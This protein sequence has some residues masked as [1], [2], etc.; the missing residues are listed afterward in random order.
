MND[1][2]DPELDPVQHGQAAASSAAQN[3]FSPT[4]PAS[5]TGVYLTVSDVNV[6]MAQLAQATQAATEAA[7]V[8]A[9]VVQARGSSES[10]GLEARDLL[11]ILPKPE[12]F[13]VDKLEDEH[14]RWVSWYWQFRQY[15][16]AVDSQ[17]DREITLLERDLHTEVV[18]T[19]PE[20]QARSFQLYALLSAL[21][22]GRA[23]QI[24]KQV[25]QQRGY[26]A[27][28]MLLLQ[29]QPPSK[30][31]SLGILSALTQLKGFNTKE[32]YLP[33][34][35]ELERGFE[36]YEIASG[37]A[38]QASLKSALLLRS[39]SGVMRQHISA[40]LPEDASYTTLREAILRYERTQFKWGTHNLFGTDPVLLGPSVKSHHEE[41][42][43]M[44]VDA[45]TW[46]GKGKDGKG[47]GKQ[48]KGKGKGKQ[49][50]QQP[51]NGKGKDGK[52]NHKG[53]DKGKGKQGKG[54][55]KST[56]ECYTCGKTGH[57]QRDCWQN[58]NR[59]QQVGEGGSAV[60]TV[61]PSASASNSGATA[62]AAGTV[63]RVEGGL[64]CFDMSELEQCAQD[65]DYSF[66][67][68][69]IS[70]CGATLP[71]NP[72][73]EYRLDASDD[74]ETIPWNLEPGL[75]SA[76]TVFKSQHVRAVKHG[77]AS[78]VVIDS[79]ADLSC[80]PLSFAASGRKV[81]GNS[82]MRVQ[83]AQGGAMHVTEERVVEFILTDRDSVPVIIKERCIVCDVTQPILSF[84]RLVKLGWFP[85]R[86][87][88]GDMWLSHASSGVEIPMWFKG[89][90]LAVDATIRRV[91]QSSPLVTNAVQSSPL[92]TD[93]VQSSPLV[94]DAVQSSPLVT[95]A[96]QS[97][98]SVTDAVQSSS[99]VITE[100][101]DSTVRAVTSVQVTVEDALLTSLSYGWQIGASGHFVWR[102]Q[103]TR[104]VDPSMIAP[105]S[106]PYRT[107]ML[108]R[109]DTAAWFV[110]EH[111]SQW[112]ELPDVEAT[113]PGGAQCEVITFLHV[114]PEPLRDLGITVPAG[115]VEPIEFSAPDNA[116]SRDDVAF[117][118]FGPDEEVPE[119][120]VMDGQGEPMEVVPDAPL[121]EQLEVT[122]EERSAAAP[123]PLILDGIE[124]SAS[125]G[126]AVLKAA[127]SKL[128]LSTSG[129]KTRLFN[130][131][132]SYVEKQKL[133]LEVEIA[134]DAVAQGSREPKIQ[135]V[136][137]EPSAQEKL[138]HE[139]THLPFASWCP[140]CVTM[141]AMPDR[142]ENLKDAARDVPSIAFDFCFTGYDAN[143][144]SFVCY[145][146]EPESGAALK[147]MVAHDSHTGSV[148]AVP[149]TSK[150]DVRH[151][152]IEL[153]RFAQ[154]LGHVTIELRCD[155]EPSTL[156]LQ[157]AVINARQRL[158]LQTLER[159]PSV[160]AHASQGYVE[161]A[162]DSI[163]KLANTLLDMVRHRT[164]LSL[165]SDHPVFSWAFVHS[166]W[167]LNRYRVTGNLTAYERAAGARYSG[168]IVPYGEPVFCQ[169]TPR[170]KG[171]PR[172]LLGIFLGKS[173][174]DMFIVGGKGGVR[175][176]RSVRRTG[177]PWSD[178]VKLYESL[179]G[180]PWDY[181]SGVLGTKFVPMPKLRKPDVQRLP[182]GPA[183]SG[184][185]LM[186]EAASLPPTT[187]G[188]AITPASMAAGTPLPL[189]M[190]PPSV[191]PER[192]PPPDGARAM[193]TAAEGASDPNAPD[194]VNPSLRGEMPSTPEH[195]LPVMG[196]P[197]VVQ[198]ETAQAS[199]EVEPNVAPT[200]ADTGEPAA[201]VP[202]IRTVT[203]GGNSYALNDEGYDADFEE[204]VDA[205]TYY[206]MQDAAG[207]P[208]SDE[209]YEAGDAAS[210]LW[211]V[212][213]G[214]G[215]PVLTDSEL[216]N[217]DR[218][219]DDVEVS[220]LVAKA[221]MRQVAGNESTEGMKSLS[222]K[223]VRSWR[224]KEKD[225]RPHYLRRS[226]LVAREFKWLEERQGL[227]SPATSTSV[228]KL[229]P[230][231]FLIWR[232]VRPEIQYG[233]ASIDVKDA[234]LEVPQET[235]LVADMPKDFA[236]SGKYVFLRC[237]PG[238]RDGSQRWFQFYVNYLR[239]NIQV[240]SCLENPAI[241]RTEYGPM[242]LHI[243]DDLVLAPV[244]W[245]KGKLIPLLEQRFEISVTVASVPGDVFTFLKRKHTILEHGI[246]VETPG[247]YIKHMA[248]ILGIK[249]GSS[250]NTPYLPE[251]IRPDSS[252]PLDSAQTTRFRSAL[253]VALYVSS[254]RYDISY[255]VRVLAGF[256]ATPTIL[257]MKGLHRLVKY[258]MNTAEYGVLLQP[259]LPGSSLF[260]ENVHEDGD[261]CMEVYTDADWSGNKVTRKS[262]GAATFALNGAVFHHMCRSHR[263][264]SLSSCESEW[265]AAVS[266]SCEGIYLRSIFRFMAN[267]PCSLHLKVDNSACRQLALRQGV[268]KTRHIEGR[269]LWL[270]QA[271]KD[272]ILDIGAVASAFNLG[273]LSTK[274]HSCHRLRCLL[275]LH[276]FVDSFTCAPVGA[277]S[278]EDLMMKQNFKAALKQVKL[279]LC[280][281]H[282]W[283][284][285]PGG[286]VS[287]MAKQIAM[288]TLLMMPSG[289]EAAV[290]IPAK[291]EA[292]SYLFWVAMTLM[293]LTGFVRA[294]SCIR[295]YGVDF[296]IVADANFEQVLGFLITGAIMLA[297]SFNLES[298]VIAFAILA[299]IMQQRELNVARAVISKL[300]RE[301]SE[302]E[303][304]RD[305][306][307][308][309][310]YVRV[311]NTG[312]CFHTSDCGHIR[313]KNN[314]RTLR[315]CTDCFH[316]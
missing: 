297:E 308:M 68:N 269:M 218:L 17:F 136:P 21:I 79:G 57:L 62:A 159:N 27:L 22:K 9:S 41:P 252:P 37:E 77:T 230:L 165:C 153:M 55:G 150:G 267:S 306:Q 180:Q 220:R 254:D 231:L 268:G 236:G 26:E 169:V 294:L 282:N 2:D 123:E 12:P 140:H 78:M 288:L 73:A 240:E 14:A 219:A 316:G 61:A 139:A 184:V 11:K 291:S 117:D 217:L 53:K 253:G 310:R 210:A 33:Q 187:P 246:L 276:G 60:S 251:L 225:K 107:T 260:H 141:R 188:G 287:K 255:A 129:S 201:K 296:N 70:S 190:A 29:F 277:D 113:L 270:Q 47:K 130:R 142:M 189:P 266:G 237:V 86:S 72:V 244:D 18:I 250:Y 99:L 112:G 295:G 145:D 249:H 92:V 88:N 196:S 274:M 304:D 132:K 49:Q 137:K 151:L 207:D 193:P 214:K 152:G 259:K 125:S 283:N 50:Q 313:G 20:T 170:Q 232:M 106:W 6:L 314:V 271:V 154:S 8:A 30:V 194:V 167:L 90:S 54:R 302:L 104:F 182:D 181:G 120:V 100:I 205:E 31:R 119:A 102:G 198:T 127:A 115:M 42:V 39:L 299:L 109:S 279:D 13:K 309:Y 5:A 242:L 300:V 1:D 48:Q 174:N 7:R 179:C 131:I 65:A 273:D 94:T 28:R 213:Q 89:F 66:H 4:S 301:R 178:E 226:R 202:R 101:P 3:P 183:G 185:G 87:S 32:P 108:R 285:M 234:F 209:W 315:R 168:R 263:T 256:M 81:M 221:V 171:N 74:D 275:F 195:L 203:F 67:V 162:V 126:L 38:V 199:M 235:P 265:Y 105:T 138:L 122:G 175:L 59:V 163:R 135:P 186:D 64:M 272:K 238:Q 128:N 110:V 262:Y 156:S 264:V 146:K 239:S 241:M 15:L 258:L 103:S 114:A 222:S 36:Q 24:V 144:N 192:V 212:D 206:A 23:F 85:C 176:S 52:Q 35:L 82:N 116:G 292:S 224:H 118:F 298:C 303:R 75:A 71:E 191:I 134:A 111:C 204:W 211:F 63:R 148:L 248:E 215:E 166:A 40:S 245:L 284:R 95:D 25:S 10:R 97:S 84:G 223:F 257:A 290:E 229:I 157:R 164:G 281:Q 44:E 19:N 289:V 228:V 247:T 312:E 173:S 46:K 124:L 155:Q 177:R 200:E 233:I 197:E 216:F 307:T 96:V 293:I 243:D 158:G 133:S 261:H 149:C 56:A 147:C 161:K 76:Q 311:T 51:Y 280:R 83:D 98:P 91:S 58:P 34:I 45:V 143:S 286:A 160:G 227:F 16:C 305:D 278:Y 93:A 69:M 172:W 121:P 208:D 80:L 43:P